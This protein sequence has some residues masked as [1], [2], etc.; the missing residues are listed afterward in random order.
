MKRGRVEEV[1]FGQPR[2]TVA[3]T[4]THRITTTQQHATGAGGPPIQYQLTN[5]LKAAGG[6]T[7]DPPNLPGAQHVVQYSTGKF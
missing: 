7:V 2:N 4:Q 1:Q 5:V 6:T 3:P